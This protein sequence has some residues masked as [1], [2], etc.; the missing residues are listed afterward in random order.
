MFLAVADS[1]Q[2]IDGLR[3]VVAHSG[4][5]LAAVDTNAAARTR[6][7]H[8]LLEYRIIG[9]QP[10]APVLEEDKHHF[11]WNVHISAEGQPNEE[12]AKVD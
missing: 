2:E 7:H 1:L 11:G 3:V 10:Y 4:V 5:E 9:L 6:E 8:H 12:Q